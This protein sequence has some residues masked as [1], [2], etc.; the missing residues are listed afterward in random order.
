MTDDRYG[1]VTIEAEPGETCESCGHV[2]MEVRTCNA[3]ETETT[4]CPAC[5]DSEMDVRIK[6]LEV[7]N[8]RLTKL[9]R[10]LITICDKQREDLAFERQWQGKADA[11]H[12]EVERLTDQLEMVRDELRRIAALGDGEIKGLCERGLT[13]IPQLAPVI[14]QRDEAA[15]LLTEALVTVAQQKRALAFR[16]LLAVDHETGR[17]E[18]CKRPLG[19]CSADCPRVN[20]G[21]EVKP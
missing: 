3:C 5:G 7:E 15:R 1:A 20:D 12:A 9:N 4:Y 8:E 11:A 19:E 16:D 2:G 14:W 13:D 21:V 17:C 18:Y 10:D 6:N